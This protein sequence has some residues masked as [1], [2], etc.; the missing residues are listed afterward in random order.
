MNGDL[1]VAPRC[2]WDT[3]LHRY[4]VFT[5]CDSLI[6]L[7]TP[8]SHSYTC[9]WKAFFCGEGL[10]A[11]GTWETIIGLSSSL[12]SHETIL[13]ST[14]ASSS[15]FCLWAT[16]GAINLAVSLSPPAAP[17]E[18]GNSWPPGSQPAS[19]QPGVRQSCLVHLAAGRPPV[20]L[21]RWWL[22]LDSPRSRGFFPT[23]HGHL[24]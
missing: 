23:L 22:H 2:S 4:G 3:V 17:Q 14:H 9:V 19:C 13:P 12:P 10:E 18:K 5:R 15:P 16:A 8:S 21:P 7:P 20:S 1:P 11:A 24:P 6:Y